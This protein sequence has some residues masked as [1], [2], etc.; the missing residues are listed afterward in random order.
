MA[1]Y[2]VIIYKNTRIILPGFF[3]KL[4]ERNRA[5]PKRDAMYHIKKDYVDKI[6]LMA[7]FILQI[8]KDQLLAHDAIGL[9]YLLAEL[10][11]SRL[12]L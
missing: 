9:F 5:C 8:K 4:Y 11:R 3:V 7:E 1:N 12:Q 10:H 2:T 6:A